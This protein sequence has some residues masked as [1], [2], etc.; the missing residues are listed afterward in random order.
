MFLAVAVLPLS[1]TPTAHADGETFEY[2]SQTQIEASGG[3]ANETALFTYNPG[4]NGSVEGFYGRILA[5]MPSPP[6][7]GGAQCYMSAAIR[8]SPTDPGNGE[9]SFSY[10]TGQEII[11]AG[12]PPSCT[13][14]IRTGPGDDEV[15]ANTM[16]GTTFNAGSITIDTSNIDEETVE[17]PH[18]RQIWVV[19]FAANLANPPATDQITLSDSSGAPLQVLSTSLNDSEETSQTNSYRQ[20]RFENIDAGTY[21]VCSRAAD[22]CVIVTKIQYEALIDV[23]IGE[24]VRIDNVGLVRA[25]VFVSIGNPPDGYVVPPVDLEV[26]E[27]INVVGQFRARQSTPYTCQ[28]EFGA[29]VVAP[30]DVEL[31]LSGSVEGIPAGNYQLC[32]VST[33]ECV[34]FTKPESEPITVTIEAANSAELTNLNLNPPEEPAETCESTVVSLGWILCPVAAFLLDG[35]ENIIQDGIVRSILNFDALDAGSGERA[36]LQAV[37]GGFR[38]IANVGFVIAFFIVVYAA[39]TGGMLSAYDTKKLIPKLVAGAVFVQLS[40]FI[41]TQLVGLFNAFG[42]TITTIMLAPLPGAET[43]QGA[44][45]ALFSENNVNYSIIGGAI[46]GL[47]SALILI[48]VIIGVV[49]S[50]VGVL[51]MIVVFMVRNIAL[52]VLTVLSPL[53]FAAWILPNTESLFRQWWKNFIQLLALFPIAMAFLSSGRLVSYVWTQADGGGWANQWIGMIA[54]F[55]PYLIAPKMF[56]FAGGAVRGVVKSVENGRK[57]LRQ[58]TKQVRSF[59][60]VKRKEAEYRS[61]AAARVNRSYGIG[62]SKGDSRIGRLVQTGY[63]QRATARAQQTHRNIKLEDTKAARINIDANRSQ[64]RVEFQGLSRDDEGFLLDAAGERTVNSGNA[65]APRRGEPLVGDLAEVEYLN[66]ILESDTATQEEQAAAVNALLAV[67]STR[68]EAILGINKFM[69]KLEGEQDSDPKAG[70]LYSRILDENGGQLTS[71]PHLAYGNDAGTIGRL[72]AAELHSIKSGSVAAFMKNKS[73]GDALVDRTVEA[74][75][76]GGL[77]SQYVRVGNV[78]LMYAEG[79]AEQRAK[80]DAQFDIT[81]TPKIDDDGNQ[82]IDDY[83]RPVFDYDVKKKPPGSYSATGGGTP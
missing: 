42:E 52:I 35:L 25:R 34:N 60:P 46:Q 43:S 41:S 38:T 20:V 33:N 14:Q 22:A 4:G 11:P 58:R 49:L 74:V 67:H 44:V 18:Q 1:S 62:G 51:I 72:D 13:P 36:A 83:G 66:Q 77:E 5:D 15:E 37:W 16:I 78:G 68:P 19:S 2:I 79:D 73:A 30:T 9:I 50:I 40:F 71:V 82:A 48:L 76:E 17:E 45:N 29:C 27:G 47:V 26:R 56:S 54:L 57:G 70:D 23:Q 12:T 7:P 64:A 81:A 3:D 59:D 39:A 32:I 8:V 55:A 75:N 6:A 63:A 53:A 65:P 69:T 80:L 31:L 21:E 24:A 10:F 61:R 28:R